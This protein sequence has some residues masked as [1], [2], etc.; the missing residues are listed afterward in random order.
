VRFG[1]AIPQAFAFREPDAQQQLATR[2]EELGFDSLWVSDHIIVPEGSSYIPEG[3]LEPL[4]LLPWLAARTGPG[5]T[6]GTSVLVLPYRDPVFLAKYLA[7]VDV[8]SGGRLVV[9]VGV[10]WLEEEFAALG[11]PYAERGAMTDE[12]L[13]VLR[14]LWGTETSSF[15]GR[16]KQYEGMRLF[17]KADT[18]RSGTIPLVV[19]GNTPVAIR[20]AAEL[21]DGWHPINL[22]PGELATGVDRYREAC[23][24]AGR[25]PGPVVLRCMP[26]GRTPPEDGRWPLTGTTEEM[27]EDLRGY[28]AAGCDE[29]M[30]SAAGRTVERVVERLDELLQ[31]V[32]PASGVR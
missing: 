11:A 20:R 9:G 2:I 4:A 19:G 3:M 13:R 29:V 5:L 26:G 16:W 30:V 32:V 1:V 10:G 6:L 31:E 28:A 8:L 12:Y 14:N 24:A 17:P 25:T 7:T 27:A 22:T 18:S 15:A 23:A 21:G